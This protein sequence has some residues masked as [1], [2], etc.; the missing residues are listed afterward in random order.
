MEPQTRPARTAESV[1]VE[2]ATNRVF[3]LKDPERWSGSKQLV[4]FVDDLFSLQRPPALKLE[5]PVSSEYPTF[6]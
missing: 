1:R 5:N 3:G 4:D 6:W 2:R